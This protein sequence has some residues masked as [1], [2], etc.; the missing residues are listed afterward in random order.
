MNDSMKIKTSESLQLGILLSIVGGFLD[1]Y[2]FVARGGVFANAQT[3]NIVFV[4][5]E[6]AKG[7]WSQALAYIPPIL[8]FVMGVIVSEMIKKSPSNRLVPDSARA[9]LILEIAILFI[10]GFIPQTCGFTLQHNY[11]HRKSASSFS[12]SLYS[13]YT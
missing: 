9:I 6:A 7:D 3:G 1:S 11:V 8:A 12:C 13:I 10:I 4:G 5:I 2:T